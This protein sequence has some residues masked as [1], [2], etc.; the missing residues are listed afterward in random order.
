MDGI[1]DRRQAGV[2]DED[3]DP[4]REGK[5]DERDRPDRP[6]RI[7]EPSAFEAVYILTLGGPGFRSMV[8]GLWMYLNAFRFQRM[9]YACAIGVMLFLLILVL[10]ILNLRFVRT[11]E[12]LQEK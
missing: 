4:A 9:G 8:P 1:G 10:T 11:A 7:G 6:D 5:A 12:Q 3:V 2:V